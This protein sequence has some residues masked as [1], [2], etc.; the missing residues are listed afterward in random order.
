MAGPN[1]CEIVRLPRDCPHLLPAGA[2]G[3]FG[4]GVR[5]LF[6][7]FSLHSCALDRGAGRP[8]SCSKQ[9]VDS[10]GRSELTALGITVGR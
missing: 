3:F 5:I 9:P 1:L 4:G 8:G 6:P 10:R 7:G 2:L